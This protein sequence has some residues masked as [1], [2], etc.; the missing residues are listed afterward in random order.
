ML[1]STPKRY[2]IGKYGASTLWFEKNYAGQ[3]I[4][5][6]ETKIARCGRHGPL[7]GTWVSL[8]PG[9]KVSVAYGSALRVQLN[10]SDGV[11]VS[12]RAEKRAT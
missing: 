4:L 7:I 9:W 12:I 3:F 10:D 2:A 8:V 1:K 5:F 11:I 6:G